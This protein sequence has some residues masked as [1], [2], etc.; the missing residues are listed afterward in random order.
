MGVFSKEGKCL[1]VHGHE[2]D[3]LDFDDDLVG[4]SD[5][6]VSAS[7]V[8]SPNS[9]VLAAMDCERSPWSDRYWVSATQRY[10]EESGRRYPPVYRVRIR[11]EAEELPEAEA[12]AYWTQRQAR[13]SEEGGEA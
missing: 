3:Y 5:M 12:E 9:S 11:V 6:V 8:A 2:E 13:Y 4:A 1:A 10:R 7:G